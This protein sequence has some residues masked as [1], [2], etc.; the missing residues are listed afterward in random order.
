VVILPGPLIRLPP[1]IPSEEHRAGIEHLLAEFNAVY[2]AVQPCARL[3]L[4]AHVMPTD[5]KSTVLLYGLDLHPLPI[6][7]LEV[8]AEGI[9]ATLSFNRT[10]H[11]TFV[12]W[13]AL[14]AVRAEGQRP[15]QRER[16]RAV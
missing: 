6:P 14:V 16:L 3:V 5:E 7:D 12:P 1:G 15:Q 13:G 11:K 4:P 2:V 9:R 8:T 10:P